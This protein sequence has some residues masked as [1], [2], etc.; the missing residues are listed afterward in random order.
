MQSCE[1]SQQIVGF[2]FT[3]SKNTLYINKALASRVSQIVV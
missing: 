3:I 1:G 2:V